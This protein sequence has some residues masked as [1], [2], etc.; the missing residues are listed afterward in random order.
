MCAWKDEETLKLFSLV[1]N[2]KKKNIPLKKAFSA[3]AEQSG[4]KENSVRNYYYKILKQIVFT[5]KNP[6]KI[7]LKMHRVTVS[8]SFTK[9]EEEKVM[10]A[11]QRLINS[12]TSLRNACLQLAGGD[13][14]KMLRYQNKFRTLEKV[15]SCKVVKM[16]TKKSRLTDSEINSLF[17]GL[18]RLIKKCAEEQ[19]EEKIGYETQNANEELRNVVKELATKQNELDSLKKN[20]E[21]LKNE[22]LLLKEELKN[23]RSQTASL[24]SKKMRGEKISS[25]KY[26]VEKLYKQEKLENDIK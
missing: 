22:R 16:P 12:G 25:L 1:E 17:M 20:F 7:N 15:E 10:P 19:A 2:Y 23:L 11:I 3:Y 8:K 26:F 13:V 21:M 6:L 24:L 9:E 5:K 18:V 4:R 14:K